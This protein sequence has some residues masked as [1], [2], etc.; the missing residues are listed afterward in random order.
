MVEQDLVRIKITH[1]KNVNTG[2][3]IFGT[4]AE[5]DV[6]HDMAASLVR[7]EKAVVVKG[8]IKQKDPI[9]DSGKLT[10]QEFMTFI[11]RN[12]TEIY[13]ILSAEADKFSSNT[14]SEE[15]DSNTDSNETSDNSE[16]AEDSEDTDD[17]EDLEDN[18]EHIE[19]ENGTEVPDGFP[20]KEIL[21]K[22]GITTLEA[23]PK[24][25]EELMALDQMTG[26]IANQIGVKL[27]K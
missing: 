1:P 9:A 24:N 4:G 12:A 16:E 22:N 10:N 25:K 20:G 2:R 26:R 5:Y 18:E 21:A 27:G 17:E 15:T 3:Q 8:K 13:G 11:Q 14:Q 7:Q 23:I 6:D 19:P